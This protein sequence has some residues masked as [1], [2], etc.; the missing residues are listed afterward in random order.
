[1][2]NVKGWVLGFVGACMVVA[3]AGSA[4]ANPTE[5]LPLG[6]AGCAADCHALE[7][8]CIDRCGSDKRCVTLCLPDAI[9]CLERC[10]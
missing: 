8:K 10:H 6:S 9:K 2:K 4:A 1:M 5:A 7:K 3:T